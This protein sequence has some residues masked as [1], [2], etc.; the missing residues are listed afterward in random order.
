MFCPAVERGHSKMTLFVLQIWHS[1]IRVDTIR[2]PQGRPPAVYA[3]WDEGISHCSK[4][5]ILPDSSLLSKNQESHSVWLVFLCI[6]QAVNNPLG[7]S[8]STHIAFLRFSRRCPELISPTKSLVLLC[9]HINTPSSPLLTP[10]TPIH[11]STL[12]SPLVPHTS[13]TR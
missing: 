6:K 10:H 12:P 8:A 5:T 11:L 7:Y 1:I 4:A 13:S 3:I 2:L 9:Q